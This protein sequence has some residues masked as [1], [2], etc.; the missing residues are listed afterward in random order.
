MA[1]NFPAGIETTRVTADVVVFPNPYGAQ[2]YFVDGNASASGDG[3]AWDEAFA[4]LEEAITASNTSIALSA[5]RWW[6]RR[7]RIFVCGDQE[8]DEDLTILPEKCDV[9][10]VGSDLY[11]F[12][13][14]IGYHTIAAT[15]PTAGSATGCRFFNCGFQQEHATNDIFAIPAGCHGI[16]FIGCTFTAAAG[17]STGKVL[18]ITNCAGVRIQDC[19]ITVGAGSMSNIFAVGISIEGTA[20]THDLLIENCHIT[21]TECITIANGT[22]MGSMIR[23]CVLRAVGECI[24]DDSDDVQI[25]DCMMI[26][27]ANATE[28]GAGVID[29][30]TA[31]GINCK[32]TC[33]DH[34]NAPWPLLGTLAT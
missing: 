10:G 9:I 26:S 3:T 31:L 19:L 8:I 24:D 1:T 30:N 22:L 18:E 12:P 20:A 23:G 4:T 34:L 33:G 28:A 11:P 21:A 7:N 29:A 5:N 17:G 2:D 32:I 27:D 6:A 14:I 13:R 15:R 25:V 16:S